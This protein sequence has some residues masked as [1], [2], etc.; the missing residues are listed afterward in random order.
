MSGK[1]A[2]W[3]GA[4]SMMGASY[5]ACA[6]LWAAPYRTPSAPSADAPA[7]VASV[8]EPA[9]LPSASAAVAAPPAAPVRAKPTRTPAL[10]NT[11]NFLVIGLD[12]RPD[13]T[14]PALADSLVLVVLDEAR[15]HVGLVSIP[16]D[17]YVDI[18]ESGT[19]RINTVY[20]VAKRT[21]RE[22]LELLSRV[23][24]DTLK[25]PIEHAI[26]LDLGVFERAVDAVGGVE[27]QVPC[28]IRDNF[29]DAR[30]DG[31]RR[32]LDL[33]EGPQHL[34]GV[35]AAMYARSRHGR[36]DFHRAR[37]QQAILLGVQR[38]LS[39]LGVLKL[40]DLWSAFESSIETDMRRVELLALARRGM[41][42][43]PAHL[44]GLVLGHDHVE[45]FRT[46]EGKSVLLPKYDV[47]DASLGKLFSA[48]SPGVRPE[49]AVCEPK[50]A[51]LGPSQRT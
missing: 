18:P 13:G 14:G 12:R 32:L 47:I 33:D 23:V 30:V 35:T 50:N 45:G 21:H 19:D 41:N 22:P 1:R 42:T 38:A 25:L 7:R 34:D 49:H 26:A 17:L 9:A 36:S 2:V 20:Q 27:V 44:H 40:P 3:I 10:T 31:G 39:G 5:L 11:R 28:A 37:R 24:S 15:E 51:A 46:P 8:P 6:W 43:D 29:V 48:P 16:R 4:L